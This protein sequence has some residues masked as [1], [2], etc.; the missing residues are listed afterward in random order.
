MDHLLWDMVQKWIKLGWRYPT[1]VSAIIVPAVFKLTMFSGWPDDHTW[2][3]GDHR[4]AE[5]VF[6]G[7]TSNHWCWRLPCR[8]RSLSSTSLS[9]LVA[10]GYIQRLV[11][12]HIRQ[13]QGW[14]GSTADAH[15]RVYHESN[16]GFDN[17]ADRTQIIVWRCCDRMFSAMRMSEYSRSTCWREIHCLGRSW[18]RITLVEISIES[19]T[20][21]W[22]ILLVTWKKV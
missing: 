19:E 12:R 20:G 2:W 3:I 14:S 1:K 17:P 22:N 11:W 13:F 4:H 7:Q 18:I 8:P 16:H 9:Q 5:V 6:E 15:R 10:T 21:P